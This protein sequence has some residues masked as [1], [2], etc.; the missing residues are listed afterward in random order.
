MGGV[1]PALVLLLA[2]ALIS[3][4]LG[5]H[6]VMAIGGADM[7]V[8]VSLLNSY[9]MAAAA[10]GFMLSNDP[11]I[12][13]GALVVRDSLVHHVRAKNGAS[14]TWSLADLERMPVR[15]PEGGWPRS[16]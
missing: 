10:A 6:P 14:G 8:V 15:H 7:P 2:N 12:A 11:L 9:S 16:G 13:T 1:D 4:L 3:S 5:I